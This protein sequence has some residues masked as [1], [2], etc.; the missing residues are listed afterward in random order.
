MSS[1]ISFG[2][3]TVVSPFA[4]IQTQ[5]GRIQFGKKCA[6]GSFNQISAGIVGIFVGDY[7]RIGPSV[8]LLGGSR[9]FSK[10]D[11]L[12][13]NQGSSDKGLEIGN[14]VLIGAGAVILPG[15]KIG[16]GAVIGAGCVVNKDIPPYCIMAGVPAR[17]VG[18]RE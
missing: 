7:V 9:H 16:E 6:L 8:T 5:G 10:R 18:Q 12:I 15:C 11:L 17:I 3:G 4:V 1:R 14:D 2:S 13:L